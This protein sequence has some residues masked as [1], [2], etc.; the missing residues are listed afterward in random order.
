M[1]GDEG[2]TRREQETP[3]QQPRQDEHSEA[4]RGIADPLSDSD[5]GCFPDKICLCIV[6]WLNTTGP[7]FH[8]S[9]CLS[10][11]IRGVV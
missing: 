4:G 8:K 1:R 2:N 9:I 11:E 10:T 3:A 6:T 5:T 7:G